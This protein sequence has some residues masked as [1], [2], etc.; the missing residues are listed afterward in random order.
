MI[1]NGSTDGS[2]ELVRARFPE[3][4]VITLNENRSPGP[5]HKAGFKAATTRHVCLIDNDV[6][7]E[8]DCL[9]RLVDAL[10]RAPDATLAMPRIV[11]AHDPSLIQFDVAHAHFLGVMA[12]DNPE[13][14]RNAAP[15]GTREIG[16][17]IS[18]C[19]LIDRER[20]G[21]REL[22]NPDF[23]IYQE[24]HDLGLRARQV[25]HRILAVPSAICRHGSGTPGLSI[26]ATGVFTPRRI[27]CTIANRWRVILMRYELRTIL[28]MA[29]TLTLFEVT[30]LIGIVK[31]G[32][33]RQWLA[34]VH[35]VWRDRGKI[36]AERRAWRMLRR[37]GDGRVLRGWRSSVPPGSA[38]RQDQAPCL[39]YPTERRA[40]E[41]ATCTAISQPREL[42]KRQEPRSSRVKPSF[43]VTW[44]CWT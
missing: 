12:L 27:T 37:T 39:L 3:V 22:Q 18:A 24:D 40:A 19:F 1:D 34:A 2:V 15:T 35:A 14:P 38:E 32:W 4:D 25:G 28:L 30:Q 20:W 43:R 33:Q 23:F 41:L 10:M 8:P 11:H 36:A 13:T 44:K 26:R 7:P 31:K 21:H 42:R 5:S 29:P 17:I 6:A 9:S 16:S